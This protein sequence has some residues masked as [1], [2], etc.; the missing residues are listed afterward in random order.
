M[1]EPAW[2]VK[3]QAREALKNGQPEEAHRLLESLV[4]SGDRKVWALRGDVVRGY[5]DRAERALRQDDVEAAWKDVIHVSPLA[6]PVDPGVT[7]IKEVLIRLAL[8]EVR[9]M[10]EAGKPLQALEAISRLRERPA[11][12]PSVAPLEEAARHWQAA[13]DH[14]DRGEYEQARQALIRVRPQLGTRTA[15]LD[16]YEE[17]VNVRDDRFR[18][19]WPCLQSAAAGVEWREMLKCADEVLAMAPRHRE[20]QQ[21]RNR[22]WQVLQPEAV[23]RTPELSDTVSATGTP[24]AKILEPEALPKRFFLWIDGVGAYLVCLSNRISIGQATGDGPVDVPLFAD[25]SRI[26][27]A[28]TRDAECYLLEASKAVSLN[29]SPADKAVLQHGDRITLGNSCQMTFELPVP[30]GLSARLQ[31][32]GGRRLPMAVDSVLLM[33]D[34]LVLGSGDKVHVQIPELE[35]PV[36]LIRQK[37]QLHIKW[38]GEF[39]IENTLHQGRAS[40]PRSGTVIADPFTF[41]IEPVK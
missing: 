34:M 36:Y 35:K 27:A 25:V 18:H 2:M 30:G 1:R 24:V 8:A 37:D 16:R 17:N 38:D 41:A 9:A 39:R 40:L 3:Y 28:L 6:T 20:A 22:A 12:S 10:L 23:K 32:A 29:N 4:A 11:T 31:L 26:H 15:G 21:A 5:V 14:A 19:A 13:I 7:R 33:A